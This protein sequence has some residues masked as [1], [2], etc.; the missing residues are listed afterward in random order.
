MNLVYAFMFFIAKLTKL[1]MKSVDDVNANIIQRYPLI[2]WSNFFIISVFLMACWIYYIRRYGFSK[3]ID[4]FI[5]AH[6]TF[7]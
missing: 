3:N 2:V 1:S 7:P 6:P 4:N 5:S